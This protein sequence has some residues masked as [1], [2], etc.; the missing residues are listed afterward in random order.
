MSFRAYSGSVAYLVLAL[1]AFALSGATPLVTR[2]FPPSAPATTIA[3]TPLPAPPKQAS[4]LVGVAS[5]YGKHWQG[6]KTASGTRF[7]RRKL[8]AADRDLPLNTRVRVTNLLNGRSVEVLVN[9][10]GPYVGERVLDLSEAAAKRLGMI[11]EGLA[12]VRI[13]LIT[14]R[15]G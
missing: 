6:R 2:A 10:R 11:K 3:I 8:T 9:D 4:K 5:W 1:S 14:A 15:A 13:D 7:D 12:P